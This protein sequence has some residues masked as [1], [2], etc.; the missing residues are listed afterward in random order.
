MR[1]R[2]HSR[3]SHLFLPECELPCLALRIPGPP[4]LGELDG[5]IKLVGVTF[6]GLVIINLDIPLNIT[7]APIMIKAVSKGAWFLHINLLELRVSFDIVYMSLVLVPSKFHLEKWSAIRQVF[8][9]GLII[10]MWILQNN[11]D[12]FKIKST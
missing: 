8:F 4:F 12:K 11:K 6:V 3:L 5:R 9:L 10:P 7:S 2:L 1:S